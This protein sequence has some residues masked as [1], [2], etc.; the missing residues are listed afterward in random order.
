LRFLRVSL[1]AAAASV[2][3]C[4]GESPLRAQDR[5]TE[6]QPLDEAA[7]EEARRELARQ[8]AEQARAAAQGAPAPAPGSAPAAGLNDPDSRELNQ[9]SPDWRSEMREP[10]C[11]GGRSVLA[12]PPALKI[13]GLA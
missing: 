13:A 3:W 1:L 4:C 6:A 12:R 11:G 10:L 2:I 9:R 7:M 5:A 8:W